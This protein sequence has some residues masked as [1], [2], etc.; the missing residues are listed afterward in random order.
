MWRNGEKFELEG[1]GFSKELDVICD[2][3][4]PNATFSDLV[5]N[6]YIGGQMS[7]SLLELTAKEN[8]ELEQ[9]SL[10]IAFAMKLPISVTELRD[11]GVY[12]ILS[13]GL[14]FEN[15]TVDIEV[16]ETNELG[17]LNFERK[18]VQYDT[19]IIG[20]QSVEFTNQR[21]TEVNNYQVI[22]GNDSIGFSSEHLLN[23]DENGDYFKANT[24]N[25]SLASGTDNESLLISVVSFVTWNRG[26]HKTNV[27]SLKAITEEQG[28][29][30]FNNLQK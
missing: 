29:L 27:R 5:N 30:I 14:N 9:S 3:Q 23:A 18:T 19:L 10:L 12:E 15:H 2:G 24:I 21:Q 26:F 25:V 17:G 11:S 20:P 4:V 7:H 8:E 16:L 1:D 6:A 22:S 13:Q 28:I